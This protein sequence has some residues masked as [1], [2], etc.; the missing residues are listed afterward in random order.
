M[1]AAN[2]YGLSWDSMQRS[3][4]IRAAGFIMTKL[5]VPN[6][7]ENEYEKYPRDH[8]DAYGVIFDLISIAIE[9]S[10]ELGINAYLRKPFNI[11]EFITSMPWQLATHHKILCSNYKATSK[12]SNSGCPR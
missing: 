7:L 9:K 6:S 4:G 2:D 11:Y 8:N 1:E 12:P 5:G 3:S 10:F